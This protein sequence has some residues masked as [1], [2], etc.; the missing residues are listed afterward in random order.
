MPIIQIDTRQQMNR[1]H[2]LLKEK[3]FESQGYTIVKSKM[4]VGDYCLPGKL[5]VAVD[6]K[7]DL[8]E[9][10]S[11]LIQ[12]HE[13]FRAEADLALKCG[14]KLYVLIED[15]NGFTAL[16]DIKRW[17]NPQ[18]LRWLKTKRMAERMGKP[19]PRPPASNVQLLKIMHSM[20]RDHGVTFEIVPQHLC[21]KRILELLNGEC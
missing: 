10:Y 12:D 20:T 14:I 5:N 13:R 6:T 15:N 18:Y 16:E 1:K 9:L 11:N 17:K 19:I 7:K 8:T 4:L 2:H 3:Y 21:G